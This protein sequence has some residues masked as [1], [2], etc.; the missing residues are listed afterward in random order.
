MSSPQT[1]LRFQA[2]LRELGANDTERATALGVK[3]GKTVERLR[4]RLPAPLHP[5]VRN[6]QLLQALLDDLTSPR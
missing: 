3:N 4:R 1:F 5:F 6:P 2:A